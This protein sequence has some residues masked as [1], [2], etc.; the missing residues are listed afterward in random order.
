MTFKDF[1]KGAG[2]ASLAS[3]LAL[4]SIKA[5][6][7]IREKV[8]SS[9]K[10]RQESPLEQTIKVPKGQ[11]LTLEQKGDYILEPINYQT[12]N[13]SRD[14]KQ[15]LLARMLYGEARNCSEEEKAAIAYTAVNRNCDGKRWNG[16]NNLKEVLLKPKQYSCFNEGDPNLEKLKNPRGQAWQESMQIAREVLSKERTNLD[17][18]QTHYHTKSI[19]PYWK[20][21]PTMKS[22]PFNSNFKHQFYRER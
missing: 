19:S 22:K 9:P 4:G 8:F 6:K 3:L 18:G 2:M 11:V 5:G 15:I 16:E 13:Y 12:E 10:T 20:D 7:I 17:K 14:T 21:A 1:L